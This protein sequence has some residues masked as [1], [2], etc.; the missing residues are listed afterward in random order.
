M[1]TAES[2]GPN[3]VSEDIGT[4]KWAQLN[5]RTHGSENGSENGHSSIR[6]PMDLKMY[7]VQ[8]EEPYIREWAQFIQDTHGSEN[9]HRSIRRPM[10][11]RICTVQSEDP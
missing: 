2:R 10:D 3:N 8:S 5:Q 6:T 11:P 4:C 9:G 7:T 1:D